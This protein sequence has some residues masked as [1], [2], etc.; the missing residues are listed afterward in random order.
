LASFVKP[1]L[2]ELM[3]SLTTKVYWL[4]SGER[5]SPMG[6]VPAGESAASEITGVLV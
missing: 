4:K 2:I 1:G 3:I 5:G 6:I